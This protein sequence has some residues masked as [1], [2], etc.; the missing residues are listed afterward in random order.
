MKKILV[1]DDQDE[2]RE[3]VDFTL[4]SD[5]YTVLQAKSGIDAI[6]V[7]MNERPDLVLM[8]IMMPGELDGLEATRRIKNNPDTQ[9]IVIIMLTGKGQKWD[10]EK[11][12]EVGASEYFV[13]PFSPLELINKVGEYID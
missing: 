8:D 4:S 11:G 7:I 12:F 5:N 2:V 13:K 6:S 1:V 10:Y 9:D 3:L